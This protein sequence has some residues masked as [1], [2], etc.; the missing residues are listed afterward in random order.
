MEDKDF[1]ISRQMV[2]AWANFMKTGDPNGEGVPEWK[3]CTA[4]EPYVW[5]IE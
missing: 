3:A 4:G 1:E 5:E 2:N